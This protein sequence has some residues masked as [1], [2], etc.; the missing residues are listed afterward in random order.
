MRLE[1]IIGWG[2]TLILSLIVL[3]ITLTILDVSL[4]ITYAI[5][6]L[7]IATLTSSIISTYNVIVR[8]LMFIIIVLILSIIIRSSAS[9]TAISSGILLAVIIL[10]STIWYMKSRS[11]S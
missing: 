11:I 2:I 6:I 4:M 9:N 8:H 7:I 10:L 3:Y 1:S 5:G